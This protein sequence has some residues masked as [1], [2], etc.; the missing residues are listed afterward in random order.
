SNHP[1][2]KTGAEIY[3]NLAISDRL[4]F[5]LVIYGH[6]IELFHFPQT[7]YENAENERHALRYFYK[8]EIEKQETADSDKLKLIS[9]IIKSKNIITKEY[10][11]YAFAY[12]SEKK[13]MPF[14][15]LT[16][17]EPGERLEIARKNLSSMENINKEKAII[18]IEKIFAE[19]IITFENLPFNEKTN[20]IKKIVRSI[21]S[22]N[23]R[24]SFKIF[25]SYMGLFE[26]NKD[27]GSTLFSGL[28]EEIKA[29]SKEIIEIL[30]DD[31]VK[32]KNPDILNELLNAAKK[33]KLHKIEPAINGQENALIKEIFKG[34]PNIKKEG[35]GNLLKIAEIAEHL[36]FNHVLF[37]IN[38]I[39]S[40][41]KLQREETATTKSS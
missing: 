16:S 23:S 4:S 2:L 33:I 31:Y 15:C 37:H 36:N 22:A 12:F 34:L 28:K 24:E 21:K 7:H 13:E 19:N 30:I 6:L 38:N 20:I 18:E 17:K 26:K 9:G 1:Q 3:Q 25:K 14:I 35:E 40:D 41:M 8:M 32:T 39:L 5:E 11:E 10:H 27:L 29:Y